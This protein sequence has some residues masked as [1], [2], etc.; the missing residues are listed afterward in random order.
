M[1][2]YCHSVWLYSKSCNFVWLYQTPCYFAPISSILINTRHNHTHCKLLSGTNLIQQW[3]WH[4]GT[5][6]IWLTQSG[7]GMG[8]STCSDSMRSHRMIFRVPISSALSRESPA[9]M[10]LYICLCTVTVLVRWDFCRQCTLP[11]H[12]HCPCTMRFL[13]PMHAALLLY[14]STA[15]TVP[16]LDALRIL[17]AN[18]CCSVTLTIPC[19]ALDFILHS[20][21]NFSPLS[22]FSSS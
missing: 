22:L 8:S 4:A 13:S 12:C 21:R 18:D 9:T 17:A 3:G 7:C 16:Y 11:L 5:D 2:D 20:M 1:S 10:S 14:S 19:L 6:A 15:S